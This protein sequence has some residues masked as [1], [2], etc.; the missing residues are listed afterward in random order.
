MNARGCERIGG[1]VDP[2]E[3]QVMEV[4]VEVQGRAEALDLN[5]SAATTEIDGVLPSL[6][7]RPSPTVEE[8]ARQFDSQHAVFVGLADFERHF[9]GL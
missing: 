9:E 6:G 2:V 7:I 5:H 8:V 3:H 1:R 4:H